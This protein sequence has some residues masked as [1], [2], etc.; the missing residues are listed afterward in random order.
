MLT[1]DHFALIRQRRR[2]GLTVRQIAAELGH[3]PKTILKALAEPEPPPFHTP[4]RTAPVFG[5]F[6]A[7]V[8]AILDADE[9]A[10]KKQRHTATQVFRRLVQEH[11]YPGSYDQVRRYL[12][13]RRRDRLATFVP[14][15]HPPGRRCE[16]D[17]GHIHV[18]LPDGRR[19]VPVLI[20]TWSYSNTPF[21]IAL[22]TERTEAILHG[23]TEAFPFFGGV[24][25]E[26]WWD[27]P[28]TVAIQIGRGRERTLHPRYAALCSHY[29]FA[30]RFCLPATPQEKPRVENRVK[31]L[32]RMWATPVP[33]V[34]D[35]AE[36]NEHLR[37]CC[38]QARDRTCGSNSE[39]VGVR[40][41]RDLA[42]AGPLPIRA[43]EA[44]VFDTGSV[45]K[46]QTVAFDGNRY[47]VPRRSAFQSVTVKGFVDHVEIVAG[48]QVVATHPRTYDRRQRVLNPLHFLAILEQKPA[49]LD[50]AP[51]YR[52][53][54]LP[55]VFATLRTE[56]ERRLGPRAGVRHYIQ[57]LQLLARF[58]LDL[59]TQ[60]VTLRLARG[61]PTVAA[62]TTTAERL[63]Q[64]SDVE[65]SSSDSRL[66]MMTVP[67]PDLARFDQLLPRSPE[68]DD[69]D[70]SEHDAVEDEPQDPQ[71]ADDAGR[72]RETGTRGREPQ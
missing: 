70:R 66:S 11:H 63:A 53:W 27:N 40:F 39:T 32:E 38:L 18:D 50:Y 4:V 8:D 49:T 9:H 31:D 69:H 64:H 61:D 72:A 12:Q 43:F 24:P 45:D 62:I 7:L 36:L 15:D 25:H 33:Q 26:V 3:S 52:D 13:A 47:S 51:V 28:T 44:C 58:S 67:R 10:P 48:H 57:V 60:A 30:G 21:A 2:D 1:V 65:M 17:F 34:K 5:P 46:Y 22:P 20:L 42:A 68:G 29:S 35:L 23:M 14:L 16:A 37:R 41:A 54:V 55:P 71:T 19:L 56:F 6:Q 59:M